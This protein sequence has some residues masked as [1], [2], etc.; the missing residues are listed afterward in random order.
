MS[1]EFNIGD[2]CRIRQWDDMEQE[3]GVIDE[4]GTIDIEFGFTKGMK[5]LCGKEFTVESVKK[6]RF[7]SVEE[8]EEGRWSI[9]ADMLELIEE[10]EEESSVVFDKSELTKILNGGS[11][12]VAATLSKTDLKFV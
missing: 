6:R 1:R 12:T 3:F 10:E 5:R 7:H 9:S 11:N 2:R 4:S 8:V